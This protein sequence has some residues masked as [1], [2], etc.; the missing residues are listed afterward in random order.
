MAME[1]TRDR[2][3]SVERALAGLPLQRRE[4]AFLVHLPSLVIAGLVVGVPL[5]PAVAALLSIGRS[6][7]EAV[8]L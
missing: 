4:A 8:L 1:A 6:S 7:A 3:G 5:A 2:S